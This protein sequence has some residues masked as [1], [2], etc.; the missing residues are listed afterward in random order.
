[1][2]AQRVA[3]AG[4]RPAPTRAAAR[5]SARRATPRPAA[6]GRCSTTPPAARPRGPSPGRPSDHSCAQAMPPNGSCIETTQSS[7]RRTAGQHRATNAASRRTSQWC[8]TADREVGRHVGLAAGVLDRAG[9][10]LH[11][12]RAVRALAASAPTRRPARPPRASPATVSAIA[13]SRWFQTSVCAPGR[14]RDGAVGLLHG[15]RSRPPSRP[16][17]AAALSAGRQASACG[18]RGPGSCRSPGRGPARRAGWC[19][20]AS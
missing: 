7:A 11:R 1:M 13:D 14:P 3:A 17:A 6:T 8:H 9:D 20:A 19:G 18:S 4:R 5:P 10:V 15:R 2:L 12:P 16:A